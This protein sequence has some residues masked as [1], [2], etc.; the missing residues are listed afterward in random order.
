MKRARQTPSYSGLTAASDRAS[1]AARA[2]SAKRDTK[3]ELQLRRAR[4]AR[5]LRYRVD[6]RDLPGR[7]DV[8]FPRARVAVFCDGDF[9]HGRG[10]LQRLAK[11]KTGHNG[12]YWVAKIRANVLRDRRQRAAL[13][14]AGWLVIRFWETDLCARP[15]VAAVAV[16]RAVKRRIR[17]HE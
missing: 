10:F 17:M 16:M 2:A 1:A 7:P 3:P 9:W 13:E 5:G 6:V 11:L 4:W 15:E 14:S 12:R 8:V